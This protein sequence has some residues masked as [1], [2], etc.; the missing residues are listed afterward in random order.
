MKLE[1]IECETLTVYYIETDSGSFRRLGENGPIEEAITSDIPGVMQGESW[2]PVVDNDIRNQV[3]Q[4]LETGEFENSLTDSVKKR[5]ITG[6]W[7]INDNGD[8]S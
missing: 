5:W 8:D 7:A 1:S 3:V 6:D 2:Q 4:L